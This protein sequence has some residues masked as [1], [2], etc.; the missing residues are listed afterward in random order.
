[1]GSS[2][3]CSGCLLARSGRK[4]QGERCAGDCAYRERENI[5]LPSSS[6]CTAGKTLPLVL[7]SGF[8]GVSG[9]TVDNPV[10]NPRTRSSDL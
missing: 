3:S 10:A 6:V 9:Y 4:E 5:G 1:M 8:E 7:C 2:R